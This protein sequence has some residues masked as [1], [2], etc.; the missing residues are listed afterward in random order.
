M[1]TI[2]HALTNNNQSTTM[3][4][5]NIKVKYCEKDENFLCVD[6]SFICHKPPH[7][8]ICL[9]TTSYGLHN[10]EQCYHTLEIYLAPCRPNCHMSWMPLGHK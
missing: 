10:S 5:C 2:Y 8:I 3:P 1:Y 6:C 7:L 9:F 4:E